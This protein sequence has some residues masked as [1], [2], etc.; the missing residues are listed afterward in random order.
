M[1]NGN[2]V[3]KVPSKPKTLNNYLSVKKRK[4][5]VSK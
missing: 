4:K 1:S 5:S 3:E 2:I